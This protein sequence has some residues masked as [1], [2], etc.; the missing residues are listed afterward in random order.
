MDKSK[1]V[2]VELTVSELDETGIDI[3]SF[4]EEPAIDVDFMFFSKAK[5]EH[6]QSIDNDKRIVVG[7]AMLPNSKITRLDAQDEEYSV[8]FSEDTIRQCQ[9]LFH[10]RGNTKRTNVDHEEDTSIASQITVIESWIVEDP[11]MDKSKHLGF[12]NIPKGSWFVSYKVDDDALWQKVKAGEVKGFSVEGLFKQTIIGEDT[13]EAKMKKIVN[14][15]DS[16]FD[17]LLALRKLNIS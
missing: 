5:L 14:S 1:E 7:A 2:L 16:D 10:K 3:I 8:Y 4:V 12:K 15:C 6:F 13:L 17:K 11:S 9:E